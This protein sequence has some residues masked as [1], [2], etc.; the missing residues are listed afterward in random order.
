MGLKLRLGKTACCLSIIGQSIC[1]NNFVG[2]GASYIVWSTRGTTNTSR[3]GLTTIRQSRPSLPQ[4]H[5]WVAP[6]VELSRSP[7]PPHL[8]Q[9]G[10]TRLA[11]AAILTEVETDQ[12]VTNWV[13]IDR[14]ATA[15]METREVIL[16]QRKKSAQRNLAH[17]MMTRCHRPL[18][19]PLLR[20]I[21]RP[22]RK[23]KR[24]EKESKIQQGREKDEIKLN[25]LPSSA[26]R[27][28]KWKDKVHSKII[29]A[30]GRPLKCKSWLDEVDLAKDI[31][32]VSDIQE[33]WQTFDT[34]LT[35]ALL[36]KLI[37]LLEQQVML[38][39]ELSKVVR[40]IMSSRA[41]MWRIQN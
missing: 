28:E 5:L 23:E 11:R 26:S 27:Y 40:P 32:E 30:S 20:K 33:A 38:D 24:K 39:R 13:R 9:K 17:L 19:P 12:T 35:S 36:D 31:S 25:G 21:R 7:G 14:P 10:P 16:L 4:T 15:K 29:A 22:E 34:K 18:P 1:R 2:A 37:D 41:I 8:L 6:L 3:S